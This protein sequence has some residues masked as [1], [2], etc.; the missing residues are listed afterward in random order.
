[1]LVYTDR[2]VA[3]YEADTGHTGHRFLGRVWHSQDVA[4]GS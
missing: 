2:G 1:M 4:E 3:E